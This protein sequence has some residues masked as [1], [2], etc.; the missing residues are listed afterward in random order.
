MKVFIMYNLNI[1]SP[2]RYIFNFNISWVHR[3][4]QKNFETLKM[5][6]NFFFSLKKETQTFNQKTQYT[7][8]MF[9]SEE[10][11]ISYLTLS[12]AHFQTHT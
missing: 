7:L 8:E 3:F 2:F 6:L 4:G 12:C 1:T 5:K 9:R 11:R 10:I